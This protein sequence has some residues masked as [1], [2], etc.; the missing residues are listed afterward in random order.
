[1]IDEELQHW[2]EHTNALVGELLEDGT[3]DEVYHT[4]EHHFSSPD[5]EV[6]EKAAIAAFK[7]GLEVEEPEEAELE[8]GEKVFAFDII[9][10]HYLD[11]EVIIDEIK[12][13]LQLAL[14]NKVDYD[15]WGTYFEE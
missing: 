7:M 5:F 1:M 2:F 6:L 14:Q 9:S 8:N 12:V 11:D 10:E 4:I 15:G 3:N 13:M